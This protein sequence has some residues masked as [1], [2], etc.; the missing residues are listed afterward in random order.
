MLDGGSPRPSWFVYDQAYALLSQ[1]RKPKLVDGVYLLSKSVTSTR[2]RSRFS[3]HLDSD[4]PTEA[5][6]NVLGLKV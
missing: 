6:K 3:S 5:V 1:S 4:Q 2:A